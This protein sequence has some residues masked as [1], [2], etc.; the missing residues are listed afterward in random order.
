MCSCIPGQSSK[1]WNTK[2]IS[3]TIT[4]LSADFWQKLWEKI[5]M[6]WKSFS[7][8]CRSESTLNCRSSHPIIK[9][10]YNSTSCMKSEPVILTEGNN[11]QTIKSCTYSVWQPQIKK[12]FITNFI[13]LCM[14]TKSG[15]GT[16][17]ASCGCRINSAL[18]TNGLN[19]NYS[20]LFIC[21]IVFITFYLFAFILLYFT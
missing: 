7:K 4:Y 6:P 5:N 10:I 17:G 15:A 9:L 13:I 18:V 3:S 8:I 16:L 20:T 1:N 21:Y 11:G 12:D 14:P 19:D 2:N